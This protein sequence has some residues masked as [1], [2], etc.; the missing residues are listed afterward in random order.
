MQ[1]SGV[2]KPRFGQCRIDG[3]RPEIQEVNP[4]MQLSVCET[5]RRPSA[6]R[7]P[8]EFVAVAFRTELDWMA[9]ARREDVLAGLAFG[10]AS[11]RQASDA[12]R[13]ILGHASATP[14]AVD[15][16]EVEEQSA[17][18]RNLVERLCDFAA[19]EPVDFTDVAIDGAH[20][21]SF[22]RRIVNACRRIPRGQTRSY[23]QLA[24]VCGSPGAAR[25]VGQVMA[26]N[27][28]P[29][30]VPCHRVVASGGVIGGFSAPQGRAMKRRLLEL[31]STMRPAITQ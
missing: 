5:P 26:K 1:T 16:F 22:G 17:T 8:A 24:A 28:Y 2:S 23:G 10:H 14:I 19:G 30:V 11:Q 13:R 4:M 18:I 27:R 31:E 7:R 15:F 21:T 3:N 25:A 6:A 29:L 20:L 12:L 9:L